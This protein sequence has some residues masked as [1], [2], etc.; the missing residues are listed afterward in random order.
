M[1]RKVLSI[2]LSVCFALALFPTAALAADA[3]GSV[4][5]GATGTL[6]TGYYVA[7]SA[8]TARAAC[9]FRRRSATARSCV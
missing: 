1:K 6:V 3:P 4:G 2:L 8:A 5:I 7:A 9:S